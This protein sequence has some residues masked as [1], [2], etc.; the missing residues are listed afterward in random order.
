MRSKVGLSE[1]RRMRSVNKSLDVLKMLETNLVIFK[2]NLKLIAAQTIDRLGAMISDSSKLSVIIHK[3]E[4]QTPDIDMIVEEDEEYLSDM[5]SKTQKIER[6][7]DA[8]SGSNRSAFN[9]AGLGKV[10][11]SMALSANLEEDFSLERIKTKDA[12]SR[13]LN[14]GLSSEPMSKLQFLQERK[15][16]DSRLDDSRSPPYNRSARNYTNQFYFCQFPPASGLSELKKDI[17]EGKQLQEVNNLLPNKRERSSELEPKKDSTILPEKFLTSRDDKPEN[18]APPNQSTSADPLPRPKDTF[19]RSLIKRG[20]KKP[21]VT[22]A[23]PQPKKNRVSL[24]FLNMMKAK[25]SR[26]EGHSQ[27]K[28][29][30]RNSVEL[31]CVSENPPEIKAESPKDAK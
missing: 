25:I 23:K 19:D 29:A 17:I 6:F 31:N 13:S 1:L 30:I 16:S 10:R 3:L 14:E 2:E 8:D 26:L 28:D 15:D 18:P 12:H 21:T 11:D 5:R 22:S 24:D 9:R 20:A 27:R 7:S 4:L